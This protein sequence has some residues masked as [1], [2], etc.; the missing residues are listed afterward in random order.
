MTDNKKKLKELVSDIFY[1]L[2]YEIIVAEDKS[3]PKYEDVSNLFNSEEDYVDFINEA[4]RGFLDEL[5][6]GIEYYRS[7]LEAEYDIYS[8]ECM[9]YSYLEKKEE[10]NND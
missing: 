10:Q 6:G 3:L 5:R 9:V 2:N 4:K 7:V 8:V 1:R